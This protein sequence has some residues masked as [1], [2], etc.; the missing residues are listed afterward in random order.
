MKANINKAIEFLL[1]RGNLPI[2]YWLKKDILEVPVEREYKNLQKF[3]A[4]IRILE[5]QRE[6]GGWCRKEYEGNPRR[7]KT[8]YIVETLH[9]AY[10]L[11]DY[12]CSEDLEEIQKMIDFLLSTQTTEGD[13]RGAY[14]NEYAPTYHAL[15]LEVLC[16]YGLDGDKRLQKG[17]RWLM[18][19]RQ[20]DGGWVIPYRTIDKSEL[21]KRYNLVA[22]RNIKPLKPDETEPFSHLVTGMVLRALAASS[23]WRKNKDARKAG[24]L[25]TERFFKADKYEDRQQARFWEET[26]YPFW[27]TDVLSS[28]DSLSKMGFSLEHPRVKKAFDW[29]EKQQESQGYWKAGSKKASLENH[30]WI[31]LSVLRVIKNFGLL[32][33]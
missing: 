1:A 25:L 23:S 14:F 30:L 12:A 20:A 9:N 28:L 3:A 7:E 21:S 29:V 15:T 31:T 24:E 6:N 26:S 8:Y 10:R 5:S 4:R 27:A 19:N 22:Q 32:N 17:Y 2:L 16:L 13:F 11:Y 18:R 33:L